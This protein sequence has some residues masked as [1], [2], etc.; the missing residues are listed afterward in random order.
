MNENHKW[1]ILLLTIIAFLCF[2]S[3]ADAGEKQLTF[4]WQQN[5]EDLPDLAKWE[6]FMSLDD[7]LP[8]DQWAKQGEIPY[9]GTPADWYDAGFT[10][11]VPDGQET[12]TYFKMTA[13]DTEGLSSLPSE[14]QEGAPTIIDFKPPAAVAD[15][16]AVFD[17]QA[18]A[19]TLTWTTDP[20]DTDI[21]SQELFTAAAAGGPYTS[22]GQG[23][24]PFVYQLAPSD[25]GKWIY[26]V[27]VLADNDGNFSANSNEAAVKLS[28]GIPFGLRVTITTQ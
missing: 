7:A 21:A 9:T 17:N 19:V 24:S 16:A 5:A 26:F 6:L 10:I 8:F 13:I 20:A 2:G 23:S 4:E 28:M 27:V 11:T 18:K 1:I 3:W 12:A 25:S 22:I 14:M 15:L